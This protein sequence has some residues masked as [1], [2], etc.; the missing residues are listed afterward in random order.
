MFDWVPN[1]HLPLYSNYLHEHSSLY[2][3]IV[4]SEC[5]KKK[6]QDYNVV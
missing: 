6:F 5:F 1:M 2:V 3:H 4:V